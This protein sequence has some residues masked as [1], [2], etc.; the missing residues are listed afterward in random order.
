MGADGGY[1]YIE[2]DRLRKDLSE[3]DISLFIR[4]IR[5]SFNFEMKEDLV[6]VGK[7]ELENM[8]GRVHEDWIRIPDGTNFDGLLCRDLL[9]PSDYTNSPEELWYYNEWLYENGWE[10]SCGY[11]W[12]SKAEA[13]WE[14]EYD[15]EKSKYLY[16]VPTP[17]ELE[18]LVRITEW[19][20]S[21]H[22]AEYLETWT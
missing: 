5:H 6:D 10:Q 16:T 8:A 4:Y 12:W 13:W 11:Y 19:I 15:R 2:L 14:A 17:D 20:D 3:A 18:A 1:Y 7:W 21:H 22:P 9:H